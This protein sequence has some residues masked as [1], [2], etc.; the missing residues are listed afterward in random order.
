MQ[1]VA[2]NGTGVLVVVRPQPAD[3]S[4]CTM[5]VESPQEVALNPWALDVDQGAAIG[6][7]VGALWAVAA[8][9]RFLRV[10]LFGASAPSSEE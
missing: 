5:V 3:F 9:F 6:V 2:D 7:S 10:Q 4:S 8:V 1:C